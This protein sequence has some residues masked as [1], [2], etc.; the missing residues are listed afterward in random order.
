MLLDSTIFATLLNGNVV[1]QDDPYL[2][3]NQYRIELKLPM[4][5]VP[6]DGKTY[7]LVLQIVNKDGQPRFLTKDVVINLSSSNITVGYTESTVLLKAGESSKTVSFK[8]T[9]NIG[10]TNIT[11]SAAGLLSGTATVKTVGLSGVPAKLAAHILP[12]KVL[13]KAG[14]KAIIV[15]ELLDRNGL[16]ARA[17]EDLTISLF[18]STTSVGRTDATLTIRRN[19]TFGTA[20]F[21]PTN[22]PGTTVVKAVASGIEPAELEVV[23]VAYNPNRLAVYLLPPILPTQSRGV[24]IVQIQDFCGRPLVANE[25]VKVILTSNDTATALLES[26]FLVIPQGM[27]YGRASIITGNVSREATIYAAAQGYESSSSTLAVR[28]ALEANEGRLLL[29]CVPQ[30]ISD[31]RTHTVLSVIMMNDN[32]TNPIQPSTTTK[33]YLTSSNTK[34]AA[35]AEV[36]STKTGYTYANLMCYTAG[37]TTITAVADNFEA[38]KSVVQVVEQVRF[39]LGIQVCPSLIPID[40]PYAPLVL[41]DVQNAFGDPAEAPSDVKVRLYSSNTRIGLVEH[42]LTIKQGENN[43]LSFFTLSSDLGNSTL[44]AAASNFFTASTNISTFKAGPSMLSLSIEPSITVADGSA[45]QNIFVSLQDMFG[46]PA[47]ALDAVKITV[48]TSNEAIGKLPT[49]L[50][51][52]KDSTWTSAIFLKGCT[53]GSTQVTVHAEGLQPSVKTLSTILLNLDVTLSAQA[54]KVYSY[55]QLTIYTSVQFEGCPISNANVTWFTTATLLNAT[56][57]SDSEGLAT[58]IFTSPVEG[59]YAIKAIVSKAGFKPTEGTIKVVVKPRSLQIEVQTPTE[60]RTFD[61]SE[62]SIKVSDDGKALDGA[63]I[64]FKPLQGN[65]IIVNNITDIQGVAKALFKCNEPIKATINYIVKKTGYCTYNGSLVIN[66]KPQPLTIT[67]SSNATLIDANTALEVKAFVVSKNGA[68]EGAKLS[69]NVVGGTILSKSSATDAQGI[70]VLILKGGDTGTVSIE[71]TASKKGYSS[72]IASMNVEVIPPPFPYSIATLS[73]W[74][75]NPWVVSIVAV[76]GIVCAFIVRVLK[77]RKVDAKQDELWLS[78]LEES[79]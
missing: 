66:V 23:T 69:W 19:S 13:A 58:A 64:E 56:S 53:E 28:D 74:Q 44:T 76:L 3:E 51:I 43:G 24:V 31:G 8:S 35:V 17:S 30:L 77:K 42:S 27:S 47:R 33:I 68:V 40:S 70:G 71:V 60:V 7:P 22:Q 55:E 61:E 50:T 9:F 36:L 75:K 52:P 45:I 67:L 5:Y 48:S 18:S 10:C 73:F 26:N 32:L 14:T 11:A 20:Y 6:A 63:E 25:D 57:K 49:S 39:K 78:Q 2:A 15:V 34:V 37:N 12:T 65:L 72:A 41:V 59:E 4:P 29:S 54:T 79:H 21:Y 46:Y 38:S 16:P 62:I 1:G